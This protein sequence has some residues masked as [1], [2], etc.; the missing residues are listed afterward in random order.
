MLRNHIRQPGSR[1]Y[2]DFI[3]ENLTPAPEDVKGG[4]S[5]RKAALKH[6]VSKDTIRREMQGTSRSF[7]RP[8]VLSPDEE[9]CIH[10]KLQFA[11]DWGYPMDFLGFATICEVL[12]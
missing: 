10:E 7:G 5:L 11:L 4:M 6:G 1:R 2:C 8:P 3:K 12:P 9:A